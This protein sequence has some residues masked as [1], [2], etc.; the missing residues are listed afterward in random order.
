MIGGEHFHKQDCNYLCTDVIICKFSVGFPELELNTNNHCVN[1][2][3][4]SLNLLE[5]GIFILLVL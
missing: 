2:Y 3:F 1:D 5:I 4:D